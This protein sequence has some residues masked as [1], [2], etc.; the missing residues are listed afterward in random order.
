M[1]DA[2]AA[3]QEDSPTSSDGSESDTCSDSSSDSSSSTDE[4][5]CDSDLERLKEAYA[6]FETF[7]QEM[8]CTAPR[9]RETGVTNAEEGGGGWPLKGGL[10]GM[11]RLISLPES[12]PPA[13]AHCSAVRTPFA[14]VL[15][16]NYCH[17]CRFHSAYTVCPVG[18]VVCVATF[19]FEKKHILVMVQNSVFF[20]PVSGWTVEIPLNKN[21]G[22]FQS[23]ILGGF[24][25]SPD[26]WTTI[27]VTYVWIAQHKTTTLDRIPGQVL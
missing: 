19:F 10:N 8:D 25:N 13:S 22:V 17:Q 5:A 18:S 23:T 15:L 1:R 2:A 3:G 12:W 4:Q 16:W 20:S 6:E 26:F 11:N 27:N 24:S 9:K 7:T 21:H 14:R